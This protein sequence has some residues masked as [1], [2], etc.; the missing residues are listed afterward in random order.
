MEMEENNI[1]NLT[2]NNNILIDIAAK[3]GEIIDVLED[4]NIT[5]KMKDILELMNKVIDDNKKILEQ[6]TNNDDNSEVVKNEN[7]ERNESINKD[8]NH[9]KIEYLDGKYEGQIINNKREGR[10]IFYFNDG[11]KYE[12]EWKNDLRHGKGIFYY[13]EGDRYEGDFKNNKRDGKGIFYYKNGDR[14][15]G[16]YKNHKK[17]GQG[18]MYYKNG[19]R[20]MG[21][22][23]EGRSI[24]KHVVLTLYGDTH[25]NHY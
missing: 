10:G 17:Q 11:D 21:D 25:T 7:I 6:I 23:Y 22:Y 1:I 16:S 13:N 20:E 8:N 2:N 18:V 15:G 9:Q 14:Y 3:L 5:N 4:S 19:N 12:G 24:G